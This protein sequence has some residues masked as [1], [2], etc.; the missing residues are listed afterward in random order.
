VQPRDSPVEEP[1]VLQPV[2][3]PGRMVDVRLASLV[4]LAGVRHRGNQ[5]G[6][7]LKVLFSRE[8]RVS[9]FLT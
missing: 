3:D 8:H 2:G 1:S 7:G 9:F 5:L 4:D 6:G